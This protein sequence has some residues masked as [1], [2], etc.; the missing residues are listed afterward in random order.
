VA[1]H[2]RRKA[3]MIAEEEKKHFSYECKSQA[4]EAEKTANVK[5]QQLKSKMVTPTYNVTI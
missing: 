4:T 1:E 3:E 5:L 2:R